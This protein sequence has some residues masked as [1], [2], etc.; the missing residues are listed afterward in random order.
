[1]NEG[2][3]KAVNKIGDSIVCNGMFIADAIEA[4]GKEIRE[5]LEKNAEIQA[6]ANKQAVGVIA[7]TNHEIAQ[8]IFN[9]SKLILEGFA[10]I[11]NELERK[12][13]MEEYY[14]LLDRIE[15]L[16]DKIIAKGED[17]QRVYDEME[18][19]YKEPITL[20]NGQI[21]I[22]LNGFRCKGQLKWLE[23]M[24][25]FYQI[26]P[27]YIFCDFLRDA[28]ISLNGTRELWLVNSNYQNIDEYECNLYFIPRVNKVGKICYNSE[29][30]C[31]VLETNS[32]KVFQLT[33]GKFPIE[34]ED[35]NEWE[36]AS[37]T[38]KEYFI[39]SFFECDVDTKI[40]W[41]KEMINY[42]ETDRDRF[43]VDNINKIS[44]FK[45]FISVVNSQIML[46]NLRAMHS[47][48]LMK[49]KSIKLNKKE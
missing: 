37:R 30:G 23:A 45:N 12:R 8:S 15:A 27:F 25:K 19:E 35:Y 44:E 36:M 11:A 22:I 17:L 29:L 46:S 9:S 28:K 43:T 18:M 42:Y 13:N 7:F 48:L 39:S 33:D 3:C 49:Y 38:K 41:L 4:A 2:Q 10:Q 1:M 24:T 5:G 40:A 47:S 32:L 21:Q 14:M 31:Q 6:K 34:Y 20:T 16:E 26:N